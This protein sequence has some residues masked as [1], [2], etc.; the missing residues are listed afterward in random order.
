M[1]PNCP[2]H[3]AIMKVI[4]TSRK[5]N[6]LF[7][8]TN[9]F[10]SV[11][12]NS[13]LDFYEILEVKSSATHEEIKKAYRLLVKKYHP[14]VNQFSE[15]KFKEIN[16]AYEILS[17]EDKREEYDE[18]HKS[19]SHRKPSPVYESTSSTDNPSEK[20]FV[21]PSSFSTDPFVSGR[22]D[23]WLRERSGWA[24]LFRS[25]LNAKFYPFNATSYEGSPFAAEERPRSTASSF[26]YQWRYKS[27]QKIQKMNETEFNKIVKESK[28]F[29]EFSEMFKDFVAEQR[30]KTGNE[31]DCLKSAKDFSKQNENGYMISGAV[32]FS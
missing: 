2:S 31:N 7:V 26:Y 13:Q 25:P 23:E 21:S 17:R 32:R 18:T 14:D 30:K 24:G 15:Q 9:Y 12:F 6:R 22:V 29:G 8:R 28:E 3:F 11:K 19:V 20:P 16:K 27:T 10:F 1:K 5:S 4:L